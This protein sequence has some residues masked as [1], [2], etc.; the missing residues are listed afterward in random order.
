[1]NDLLA[2]LELDRRAITRTA[3]TALKSTAVTPTRMN[4]PSFTSS[5]RLTSPVSTPRMA[6]FV[7]RGF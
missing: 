3:S 1:M 2:D 6:G 7:S 5:L 4:H